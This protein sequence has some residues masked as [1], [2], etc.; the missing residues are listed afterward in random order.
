MASLRL[1]CIGRKARDP[2]LESAQ[3]YQERLSRST[4]FDLIRLKEGTIESEG[5]AILQKLD[6]RDWVVALD[7]RGAG[8]TTMELHG[9]WNRWI[10]RGAKRICFIIGGADGL[11]DA[12]KSRA[13]YQL[14][15]SAM[16]LPHRF[17]LVLLLEQ[18]YRVEQI[19][20]GTGYHRP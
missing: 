12:V 10:E 2:L 14:S 17:A 1:I 19:R 18:L 11:S 3:T 6:N 7:E 15:L 13:N 9:Q 8:L 20:Q 16:T 5:E 4:K